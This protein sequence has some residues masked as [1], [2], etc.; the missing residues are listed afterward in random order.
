M[1][2]QISDIRI[3]IGISPSLQ[4]LI[5]HNSDIGPESIKLGLRKIT[6][7]GSKNAKAKV[8]TLGLVKTG[9]L[10]KSITGRTSKSKSYIG[11]TMWYAHISEWG[12]K[13]HIIK[14]N[15]KRKGGYLRIPMDGRSL[16]TKQV[17]HPGIKGY[18][19]IEGTVD[20]MQ[21]RG[22]V[23]SLF[24]KGVREAIEELSR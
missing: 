15:K 20:E 22:E 11:T 18:Q 2:L 7:Q 23:E 1:A 5:D 17:N 24:S 9:A 16:F 10:R 19:V 12:A 6:R 8:Q 21:S 3:D 13:P 4:A 14:V